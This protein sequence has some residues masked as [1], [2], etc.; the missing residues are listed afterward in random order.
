VWPDFKAFRLVDVGMNTKALQLRF[1]GSNGPDLGVLFF[2]QLSDGEKVAGGPLHGEGRA[3][4]RSG[5]NCVD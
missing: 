4:D 1:E 5:T 3:G 2:D